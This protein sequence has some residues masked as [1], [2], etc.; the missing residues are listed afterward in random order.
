MLSDTGVKLDKHKVRSYYM[1]NLIV[2]DIL[3]TCAFKFATVK[4]A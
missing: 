1:R 3:K 2:L 4:V